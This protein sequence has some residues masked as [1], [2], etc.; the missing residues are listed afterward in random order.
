MTS[1]QS[2]YPPC[3]SWWSPCQSRWICSERSCNPADCPCRNCGQFKG[4]HARSGFLAGPKAWEDPHWSSSFLKDCTAWK[5]PTLEQRKSV[6][7]KERQSATTI[8]TPFHCF[9]GKDGVGNEL[10]KLSLEI[11]GGWGGGKVLIDLFLFLIIL[12]CL[13]DNKSNSF[14]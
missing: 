13:I 14:P 2:R 10:V 4:A 5:G 12:L 9:L 6:R 8:P 7:R 3:S 11:L 1:W